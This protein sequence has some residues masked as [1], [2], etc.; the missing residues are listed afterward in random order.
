MEPAETSGVSTALARTD[1]VIGSLPPMCYV[2]R[3]IWAS[4]PMEHFDVLIM[5]AG[6]SGIDAAYHLQ[7]SCP[8]KSYVILEQRASIGGT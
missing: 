2:H 6:L 4:A 5:G 7:K 1:S 8:N 3:S